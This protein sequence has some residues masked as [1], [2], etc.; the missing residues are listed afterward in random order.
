[1]KAVLISEHGGRDKL[2]LQSVREPAARD[3]E[4]VIKV[5]AVALNH[6][7]IFVREGT[8]GTPISLPRIAGGDVAGIVVDKGHFVDGVEV[9]QRVVLDPAVVLSDNTLG[10]LGD[11]IDGGLAEYLSIPSDNAIKL[12]KEV[13]FNV[14]AALPMS[15]ATAWRMLT[16]RGL[17]QNGESVLILGASGGVGT[18]A[19][20]I[21]KM[22]GCTVYAASNSD[23][24]LGKL[25]E[26]GIDFP[27]NYDRCPEFHREIRGLTDGDG[28]DV[29]VNFTGGDSWVRSLKAVKYG[30]RIL[31]CGATS[32]FITK[33][34]IRYIW[35]REMN[36]IGSDGWQRGDIVDLIE[37]VR[38]GIINPLIHSVIPLEEVREGYRLLEQRDV[39]GK[40][41]V[42]PCKLE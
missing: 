19:I 5:G 35:R 6:L 29:V 37:L 21:A 2:V 38:Q 23:I 26:L 32:D 7:D 25:A 10:G 15:Y 1:M 17:I 27:I 39:V 13:S 33:T 42:N 14:A 20:Q 28:V 8:R 22:F 4:L 12:P 11:H 36:I 34:D 31:T 18:A 3:H 30:G 9:G 24:K 40:V 16:V 41:I